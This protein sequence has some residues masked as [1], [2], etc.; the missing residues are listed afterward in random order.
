[1]STQPYL[2]KPGD[3]LIGIGIEH[4]VD[5]TT[6]L[7][8]NPQYQPNPDLIVA[9]ETLQLP[10]PQETKPAETDFP[11][12]PVKVEVIAG[13]PFNT[14]FWDNGSIFSSNHTHPAGMV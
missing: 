5:F 1:M 12:E 10:V 9:G 13:Q 14:H 2:I 4:N 3:T 6:L 8:L 7:T 11:V